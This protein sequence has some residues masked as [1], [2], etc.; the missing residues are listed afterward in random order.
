MDFE[1]I[2]LISPEVVRFKIL[3]H[4]KFPTSGKAIA[5]TVVNVYHNTGL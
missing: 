1:F 3:K 5:N 4:I 2:S